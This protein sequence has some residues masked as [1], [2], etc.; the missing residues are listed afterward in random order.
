MDDEAE[1]TLP[2]ERVMDL[3]DPAML[4][5]ARSL[6]EEAGIRFFIKNEGTQNLFGG[7]QL[8]TGYNVFTGPPSLMV[9]P[10]RVD[11]ARELLAALLEAPPEA[12][13]H[14][15]GESGPGD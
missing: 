15:D 4:A 3:T 11:E 1:N 14:S 13:D 7:G 2:F 5:V 8:G 6:L 9:E 10:S 12:D